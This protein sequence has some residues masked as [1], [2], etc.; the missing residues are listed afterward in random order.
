MPLIVQAG[1][2]TPP[3]ARLPELLAVQYVAALFE[4]ESRDIRDNA[5]AVGTDKDNTNSGW[6]MMLHK[7][8]VDRSAA[9]MRVF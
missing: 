2:R 9:M 3:I 8:W 1:F 6:V 5:A 4:E 7:P